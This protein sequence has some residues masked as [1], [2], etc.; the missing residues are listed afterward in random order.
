MKLPKEIPVFGDTSY[1]GDCPKEEIDQINFVSW[2]KENHR[3]FFDLLIHP[4]IEGKMS[5]KQIN[6][7][8]KTGGLPI[9]AS[10]VIIPGNPCFVVE[11]KR[12]DHTKSRWQP[13]QP[14]YLIAAKSTGCFVGVA[15]GCDG[16]KEA[17]N[18]W[19]ILIKENCPQCTLTATKLG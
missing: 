14:D 1:R 15:L 8:S 19:L 16:L 6:S 3:V 5:H 9:G 18:Q 17:F 13:K 11:L 2:L 7:Y 10:D 12:R 4:R